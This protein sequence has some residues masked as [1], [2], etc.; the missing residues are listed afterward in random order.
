VI[1]TTFRRELAPDRHLRG[2]VRIPDGPPPRSAILV[3]HGFK[4]FKDWGFFPYVANRLAASGHAVVSFN[5]SGSGI[6]SNPG[7]FTELE[8]FARNTLSRELEELARV[9]ELTC[10]GEIL[11]RPPRSLGLLGH[12]R[13]GGD[14]ILHAASEPRV[15]ALVTWSALS[16]FDRWTEET[17]REWRESGRIYV[18]NSRTGQHM[19]LDVTLLE[20]FEANRERLDLEKAAASVTAPWLIV[21]GRDDLTV[22]VGA[23]ATFGRLAPGSRILIVAGAGHTYESRHPFEGTTRQL[24]EALDATVGHFA[25]H[26][27]QDTSV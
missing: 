2:D 27:G 3:V 20:D 14:A 26:L 13:G 12:S 23:A 19:P 17:R 16:S 25:R 7:D 9:T 6:G 4:G 8:A 21:H 18:I 1:R 11:P 22:D 5:F 15:G 24:T 10:S